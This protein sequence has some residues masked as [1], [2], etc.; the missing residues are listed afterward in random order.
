MSAAL[1]R[2]FGEVV[3]AAV[4]PGAIAEGTNTTVRVRL[5]YAS[6]VGPQS[7]FVKL[8][9]RLLHRGALVALGANFTEA[10]LAVSGVELPIRHPRYY[11][12]A[13]DVTRLASV[14][15]ME[16]LGDV[17]V[18]SPAAPL[19]EPTVRDG[20]VELANLH[21]ATWDRPGSVGL[22]FVR[23]WRLNPVLSMLSSVSMRRGLARYLRRAGSSRVAL[24][25]GAGALARA[26][27]RAVER[28]GEGPRSILHG[29]PHPGNV[30]VT[31][32]ARTGFCDW[33]LVRLGHW[34]HDVGYF[35]VGGLD[36]DDRRRLERDLLAFYLDALGRAGARAPDFSKAWARYRETP[37]YGLGAWLHTLSF[38][39]FQS[40]ATS[41][42][43]V[44]RF[45]AAYEDF[46]AGGVLD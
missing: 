34:S 18:S 16:D 30:Y 35:I 10:R 11:A 40:E 38:G 7:V 25:G 14:V 21:A 26:F 19:E 29:D 6:G 31:S 33:Q 20:L 3:V 24:A 28:A 44:G 17:M 32:D 23:P 12:G 9:G 39:A 45:G 42:T 4:T 43:L 8:A 13:Y 1:R 36:V 5:E 37:A 41:L 15:V 46:G 2:C 27:A 22:G